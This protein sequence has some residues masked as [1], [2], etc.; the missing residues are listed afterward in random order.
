MGSMNYKIV[1]IGELLVDLKSEQ[2]VHSL[3]EA[4]TFTVNAGGSPANVCSN[5]IAMGATPHLVSCVGNDSFGKHLLRTFKN[6]GVSTAHIQVSTDHPTSLVVVGKSKGTPDFIAY[7]GADVQIGRIAPALIQEAQLLHTSAFALSRE[8][9]RTNIL[10]AFHHAHSLNKM[11]SVDWNYAP[12]IWEDDGHAVFEELCS[13]N[14]LLKISLDDVCRFLKKEIKPG[15]AMMFLDRFNFSVVCLTC[16]ANGVWYRIGKTGWCF[17]PAMAVK[18]VKDVT[19][20][21][22]AFWS[23][24]LFGFL[25]QLPVDRCVDIGLEVA[26]RRISTGAVLFEPT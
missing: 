10:E 7:R 16:G 19:G 13:F 23:G 5:L 15:D 4:T 8:P 22:D 20:A 2:H 26:S 17:K 24:F 9:A 11:V 6:A 18:E 21:G 12:I 1:V 3:D 14:L 25:K